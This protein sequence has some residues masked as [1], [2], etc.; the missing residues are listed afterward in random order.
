MLLRASHQSATA[1]TISTSRN[2]R[3]SAADFASSL[4]YSY[5][6]TVAKFTFFIRYVL[7][8]ERLDLE[9]RWW[10]RARYGIAANAV[11]SQVPEESVS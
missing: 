1:W 11:G 2:Q 4:V 5:P 8:A 10:S 9:F 6:Y 7:E 3:I